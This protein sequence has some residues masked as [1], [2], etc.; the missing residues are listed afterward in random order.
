MGAWGYTLIT[1]I[2]VYMLM[3]IA[4][5]YTVLHEKRDPVRAVTWIAVLV[6]VPVGGLV[7]FLFFGQNY[8][9]QKIFN[10]KELKELEIV[11]Q[12]SKTQISEL[13]NI[14]DQQIISN[15]HIIKL[16]L[17]NSKSLLTFGNSVEILKDGKDTFD[18]IKKA[19]RSAKHTIHLE[20]Y[21]IEDD[22]LGNEIAQILCEKA[23]QGLEVRVI[24]DDVGSW[25]LGLDYIK[26]L[27]RAGVK[28]HCFMPVVFPWFTS[29]INYRNH[30]KI[31]VIDSEI[32]FTGGLNIADRYIH[33]N[34]RGCWR[35]THLKIGGS[36]VKMLQMTFITDW[37]FATKELL[38][39][40]QK[41]FKDFSSSLNEGGVAMQIAVSGPDS[42]YAT[43]MQA[44]FA[45]ITH[46]KK[47][48]YISTPYFLPNETVLT[49]LKV[50]SL[51][52]IDVRIMLPSRSDSKIVHWA[53]RSYFT[54]LLEAKIKI[55]LFQQGFNHSKI[56]TVDGSFGSVGTANM[57]VRSFEDNFEVT[58]MI[59]DAKVTEEIEKQF[60]DDLKQCMKL[61]LSRWNARKHKDNFKES[62]ARLFSPLL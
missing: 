39:D 41:Y 51:S 40:K 37:W 61:N 27:R 21:I 32:G 36:A 43:I 45:A 58:A 35:D 20:Y 48:I 23:K 38:N 46:A 57:D 25:D 49:A 12:L 17:N 55:Y 30:R 44:Y 1:I 54:E 19:L 24:Y 11:E 4:T 56:M 6:L 28:I 53:S 31:I 3:I 8:R 18:S 42:D 7:V 34:K 14:S 59:Y 52:G 2:A 26:K 33:G 60:T 15:R 13:G 5:V 22:K 16:L 10:R 50:A 9:K 47:H 29:K 62:V